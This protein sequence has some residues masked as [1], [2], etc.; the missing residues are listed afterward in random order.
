MIKC[1]KVCHGTKSRA[2]LA[3]KQ[4]RN[5]GHSRKLRIYFCDNCECW[6]T[7][8][9]TAKAIAEMKDKRMENINDDNSL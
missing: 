1:G 6:H 7:T 8:S 2:K 9:F 4:L 3:I 5:K